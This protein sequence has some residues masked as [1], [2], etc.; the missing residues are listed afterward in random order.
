ML[1]PMK[2]MVASILGVLALAAHA[3]ER[4]RDL[5][6]LVRQDCGACHGM[7]LTGGLG[8]PL[9]PQALRDKPAESLVATVIGGRQGTPMP[10]WKT[11]LSTRDAEWIVEH[12]L[13]GF[14]Q[15]EP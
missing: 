13:A 1:C 6:R 2:F 11:I 7:Q 12:L 5:I 4:E 9:T 3:G 10:S 14:P 8:L 15:E